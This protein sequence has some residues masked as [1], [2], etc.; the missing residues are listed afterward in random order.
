MSV[1]LAIAQADLAGLNVSAFCRE[2]G[3]SRD[4]FYELRRR[5]EAEGE[6]GLEARSRA[7]HRVAN[8][9]P[10]DVEDLIV[11]LRK[12]LEDQGLDAGP[13]SIWDRLG[14]R[15]APGVPC[16][17]EATIW[18]VLSRRGQV[19]VTPAKAPKR[20]W[21]SFSADRANECWQIDATH[22][23]LTDGTPIEIINV[24]DDCTRLCA[25]SLAVT[26]CTQATAFDALTHGAHRWG[27][28]ERILS[29]NGPPFV[30]LTHTL[31]TLGIGLS[32]ARPY[33]PQTCGKVERFH[34]TL[35]R[36]LATHG[37]HTTLTAVQT[38]TNQ[39]IELYNHH[40]PHRSLD[41]DTPAHRWHH[42]PKS[43]PTH[44]PAATPTQ[45]H[46]V[47]VRPDGRAFIKGHYRISLGVTHAGQPATIITT[48]QTSHVFVNGTLARRLTINP[49]TFDQPLHPKPGRPP[50]T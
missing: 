26:S 38:A 45:I 13:A 27:W 12:A 7:P 23:T 11:E 46:R 3:I 35:K 16:P 4:R 32:H 18:R 29:D 25:A 33:H 9:T 20:S 10:A 49:N 34:Q 14:D 30:A 17:S 31:N 28:P 1:R 44:Q 42:T 48:G 37:P 15:L 43:G 39:F 50:T 19:Q 21:R 22:W 5:F 41:R 40:R 24:I 47:T 2:H 6:A 36:Y 8:R